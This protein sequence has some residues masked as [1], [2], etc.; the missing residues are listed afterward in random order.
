MEKIKRDIKII[1]TKKVDQ[2]NKKGID[3]KK[4]S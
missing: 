1:V 2:E 3:K 4:I